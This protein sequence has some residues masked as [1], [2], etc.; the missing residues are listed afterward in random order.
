MFTHANIVW[1]QDQL[2]FESYPVSDE[3]QLWWARAIADINQDGVMD[4]ALQ[5]NNGHGGWLG[6]LEGKNDGKEWVKHIIAEK[7][8]NGETFASGD[9]DAGD[10]DQDG[11]IDIIAVQHPG[12]W[13]HGGAPSEIYWYKNPEWTAHAIG[14]APDFIKDLNLAD[15][16]GDGKLDLVTITFE[17]NTMSIFRQDAP[18]SWT[19]VQNFKIT[20]LHE[21][22]DVGDLDGDGDIDI[23]A[24]GYFIENPGGDL[25]GEWNIHSIADKWHNQDG[26]WSRNASKVF[27]RDVNQDGKAEVFISH[28]E[29]AG[30]PVA[31]YQMTNGNK[32]KWKEHIISENFPACHTLQVFDFDGDGDYDVL[33]GLNKNRAKALDQ[34]TFPVNIFLKQDDDS[35]KVRTLSKDGIYN[36]QAADFDQDGDMDILRLSTHDATY[37]E[38]LMNQVNNSAEVK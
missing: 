17:E 27:C 24:N 15:F 10:I 5:N 23:A 12:E 30:Y 37:I 25:S 6:W 21:G 32:S 4:I 36:G 19:R 3:A 1:A 31:M 2:D 20:N 35:W 8:P 7:S 38:V 11:D 26:D 9:L 22:M 18:E 14:E 33:A 13:D 34:K 28:S 16:N 29:R